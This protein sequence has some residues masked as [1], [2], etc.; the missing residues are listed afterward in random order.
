MIPMFFL[1]IKM[2]FQK[3]LFF[4]YIFTYVRNESVSNNSGI[5]SRVIVIVFNATFNN[6]SVIEWQKGCTRLAA[7]S[8]KVY[9]LLAYGRW[10][11]PLPPPL[12]L[13]A[14]I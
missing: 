10:F 9:Q 12:K 14:M 3:L 11:S 8:D 7:A 1:L 5:G 4:L 6:I 2:L 13:V